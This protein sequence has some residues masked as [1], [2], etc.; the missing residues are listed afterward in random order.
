MA[1]PRNDGVTL[2]SGTRCIHPQ[3][4][5]CRHQ[6]GLIRHPLARHR[7]LPSS[8]LSGTILVASGQDHRRG[9]GD[10]HCTRWASCPWQQAP[11]RARRA[12]RKDRAPAPSNPPR[13]GAGF[14]PLTR[15]VRCLARA[16]SPSMAVRHRNVVLSP[17]HCWQRVRVRAGSSANWMSPDV[18]S[19]SGCWRHTRARGRG[20]LVEGLPVRQRGSLR[21]GLLQSLRGVLGQRRG[22]AAFAWG[23]EG[24]VLSTV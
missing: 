20:G 17:H 11:F 23:F 2:T 19:L 15:P 4:P 21:C 24:F 14:V 6:F 12:R 3:A 8:Q 9:G 5:D 10:H 18:S 22:R 13:R 1:P 7:G 16:A